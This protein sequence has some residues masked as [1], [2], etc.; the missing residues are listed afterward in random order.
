MGEWVGR[1]GGRWIPGGWGE[2]GRVKVGGEGV[3]EG[4]WEVSEKVGKAQKS[5]PP[6]AR[7]TMAEEVDARVVR[8]W[9]VRLFWFLWGWG[10]GWGVGYEGL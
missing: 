5:L 6:R 4:V 3:W 2:G 9:V 1:W 10:W 7:T 8:R